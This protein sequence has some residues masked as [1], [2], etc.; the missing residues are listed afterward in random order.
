MNKP[1]RA[2]EVLEQVRSLSP[3]ERAYVE[4]ELAKDSDGPD[5]GSDFRAMIRAHAK[6]AIE[7]SEGQPIKHSRLIR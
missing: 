2:D 5:D 1:A 7:H 6:R 3:E 4:A